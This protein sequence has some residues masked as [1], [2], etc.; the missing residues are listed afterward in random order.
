MAFKVGDVVEGVVVKVTGYGAFVDLGDG[1]KG[2]IHISEISNKYVKK[3]ED[4]LHEG[5]KVKAKVVKIDDKGRIDLSLK[6]MRDEV[7][8]EDKLA[9][10]MKESEEK[11]VTMNK[12]RDAGRKRRDRR[13]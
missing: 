5:D 8:F 11:I 1:Q 13:R 12:K 4:Y 10:Y 9:K 2:L 7:S 6:S 3:V